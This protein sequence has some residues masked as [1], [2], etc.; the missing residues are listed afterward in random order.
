MSSEPKSGSKRRG[1]EW[2]EIQ[3]VEAVHSPISI[4]KAY[5]NRWE[6]STEQRM[7]DTAVEMGMVWIQSLVRLVKKGDDG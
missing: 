7:M 1:C 5:R 3:P 6:D 4:H 2:D